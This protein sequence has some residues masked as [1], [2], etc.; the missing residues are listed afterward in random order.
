MFLRAFGAPSDRNLIDVYLDGGIAY[1]G[2]IPGRPDDT[3]GIGFAYARISPNVAGFD[4][5]SGSPLVRDYQAI[6]EVTYQYAVGPGFS[7]QPEFQYV[8]HPGAH[9]VSNPA[10]GLPI[11]DAAVFGL[12]AT[13]QY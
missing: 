6:I 5:L 4:A 8:F 1:E 9:G 13:V 7:V 2:L 3:I 10:D 12:R 11:G